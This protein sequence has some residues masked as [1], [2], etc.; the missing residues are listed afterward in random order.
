MPPGAMIIAFGSASVFMLWASLYY[1]LAAERALI[2][3]VLAIGIELVRPKNWIF[4][5]IQ[6]CREGSLVERSL[7]IA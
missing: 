2:Y 7:R 5:N 6:R 4:T 1:P 3:F